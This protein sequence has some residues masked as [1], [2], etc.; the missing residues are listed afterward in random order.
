[1]DRR[2]ICDRRARGASKAGRRRPACHAEAPRCREVVADTVAPSGG[3]QRVIPSGARSAESRNR[4][5]PDGGLCSALRLGNSESR[6]GRGGT[7]R[8][9]G[10]RKAAAPRTLGCRPQSLCSWS[11]GWSG[12]PRWCRGLDPDSR[13]PRPPRPPR[14]C[15]CGAAAAHGAVPTQ[16]RSSQRGRS[17]FLDSLRSLGMTERVLR[18][19]GMTKS[20]AL[21][22]ATAWQQSSAPPRPSAGSA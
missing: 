17:R 18:Y 22:R 21:A 11:R 3:P 5:R 1:M 15:S 8:R 14:E 7:R 6:G 9:G 2:R 13:A 19:L 4:D 10:P 16:P 12:T 20:D